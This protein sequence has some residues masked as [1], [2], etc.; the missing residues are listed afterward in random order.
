MTAAR[1]ASAPVVL[2]CALLL[3]AVAPAPAFY[4]P[5]VAPRDYVDGEAIAVKVRALGTA[6]C[7]MTITHPLSPACQAVKLTSTHA[8]SYDYYYL[9]FCRPKALRHQPENLGAAA[10]P[11][12]PPRCSRTLGQAR[13]SAATALSTR[14]TRY[15][16]LCRVAA[17]EDTDL[18]VAVPSST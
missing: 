14:F 13:C 1:W 12:R 18:A 7:R 11:D 5:G 4:L 17:R 15:G 10:P 9:P 16:G 2:C 3:A 8:L 6:L